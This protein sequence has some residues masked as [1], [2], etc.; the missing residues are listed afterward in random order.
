MIFKDLSYFYFFNFLQMKKLYFLF[1]FTIGFLGNAQIVNIP[2]AN[3][4]AR[5]LAATSNNTIAKNLSGNYFRI[6]ANYDGNIQIS[7]ALQV[8]LLNVYSCQISSLEGI[9]SFTNLKELNCYLNELTSLNVQGLTNLQNLNC[10]S[11][12]ISNINVQGLLNLQELNCFENQI[13]TENGV[14]FCNSFLLFGYCCML[15]PD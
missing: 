7:E 5:L 8:S 4:K 3:F 2:D 13:S 11:N 14:T 10:Y 15:L 9:Q 6:D 12:Q 1:F